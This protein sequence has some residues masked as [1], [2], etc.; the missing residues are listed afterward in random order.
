[1]I[2]RSVGHSSSVIS[3]ECLPPSWV[4]EERMVRTQSNIS[5]RNE[6][7]SFQSLKKPQ[8][9]HRSIIIVVHMAYVTSLKFL[10]ELLLRCMNK[11]KEIKVCTF[12]KM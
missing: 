4:K 2:R 8:K 5:P 3:L 1:M 9:D 11:T 6:N 7:L 10:G 12:L